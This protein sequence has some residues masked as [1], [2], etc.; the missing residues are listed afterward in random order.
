MSLVQLAAEHGDAASLELLLA[1]PLFI[2][3]LGSTFP[4]RVWLYAAHQ[5]GFTLDY[6]QSWGVRQPQTLISVVLQQTWLQGKVDKV[7]I[8]LMLFW[9]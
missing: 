8:S 7:A 2:Y 5:R 4:K 6:D 1:L 9:S 3:Y